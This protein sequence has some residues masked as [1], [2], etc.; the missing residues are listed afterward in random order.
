M[1]NSNLYYEKALK[2]LCYF[3]NCHTNKEL[4]KEWYNENN[5]SILEN[6]ILEKKKEL[7]KKDFFY[8]SGMTS[9]DILNKET[10]YAKIE[11]EDNFNDCLNGL[12]MFNKF[13]NLLDDKTYFK[14]GDNV[15]MTEQ[16][17][18]HKIQIGKI[19][20]EY[21]GSQVDAFY[22]SVIFSD[23]EI[24]NYPMN[25]FSTIAKLLC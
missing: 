8:L 10:N 7:S 20:A 19:V 14:N 17:N 12:A 21:Y 22:Y 11:N 1:E 15:F 2:K 4:G 18:S 24:E 9:M 16:A 3:L 6:H 5:V 23:G 25:I 13:I